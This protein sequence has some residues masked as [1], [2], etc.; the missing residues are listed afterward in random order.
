[1]HDPVKVEYILSL[2]RMFGFL[3]FSSLL[4]GQRLARPTL[5][6]NVIRPGTVVGRLLDGLPGK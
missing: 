3:G 2:G 1:M 6:E 4:D 5:R